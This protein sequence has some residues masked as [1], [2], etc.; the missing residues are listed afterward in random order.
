MVIGV[1]IIRKMSNAMK[2]PTITIKDLYP[3]LS[4]AEL[5]IVEDQLEQYL[6]LALRIYE[7]VVT[8]KG[9]NL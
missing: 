2:T 6:A 7:R 8:E 3:N 9:E 5:E 4:D 1:E